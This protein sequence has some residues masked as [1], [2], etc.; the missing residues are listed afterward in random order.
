[1]V[2][3]TLLL[4][5]IAIKVSREE[6]QRMKLRGQMISVDTNNLKACRMLYYTRST[7]LL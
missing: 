4:N 5:G 1:V 6:A 2:F 3:G 7:L